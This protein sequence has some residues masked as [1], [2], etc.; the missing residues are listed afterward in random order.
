M[1]AEVPSSATEFP[2]SSPDPVSDPVRSAA[3]IQD[4]PDAGGAPPPP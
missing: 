2:K 4:E 1:T 3:W